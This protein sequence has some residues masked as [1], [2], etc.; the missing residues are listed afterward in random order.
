LGDGPDMRLETS[1]QAARTITD[2]LYD[3]LTAQREVGGCLD[4]GQLQV[5]ASELPLLTSL[6][7]T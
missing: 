1:G 7:A 3:L 4:G 5:W 2:V 6:S